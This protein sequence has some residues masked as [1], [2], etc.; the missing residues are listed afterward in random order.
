MGL[1]IAGERSG[2]GKTTV[3][4]ALLTAIAQQNQSVQAFKVGPDYIDPMFHQAV[5]GRPS[6][7]LDPVLTSEAYVRQCYHQHSQGVDYCLIEGVM[8][9]FDGAASGASGLDAKGSTAHI[10]RILGLPVLLVLDC[11]RL[12][13]SVAAIAHGFRTLDPQIKLVG[14][15]LNRVAS[16]R[17]LALLQTALA[18]IRLP[19]FGV[20]RRQNAIALPDRHLGLV[21]TAE[22]D[23]FAQIRAQLGELGRICFDWPQL[24]PLLQASPSDPN[25]LQPEIPKPPQANRPRIA[26]ARDRALDRK[27]V[28]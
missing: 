21:P 11:S 1:I 24:T 15:V 25:P 22:L 4:L 10:A 13:G 17:H 16:D 12:S 23:N 18:A 27:S 14:V 9:L 8:G 28:V 19:V 20:L 5:T 6:F 7:N 26:I 3:T 2:V